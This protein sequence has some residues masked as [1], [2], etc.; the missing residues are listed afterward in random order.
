MKPG[1]VFEMKTGRAASFAFEGLGL[2]LNDSVTIVE[3]PYDCDLTA[4][5]FGEA[6]SGLFHTGPEGQRLIKAAVGTG[7]A[8]IARVSP[9]KISSGKPLNK[10]TFPSITLY[11]TG[12][13]DIC[14]RS[15]DGLSSASAGKIIV[16]GRQLGHGILSKASVTS[17][18][19]Y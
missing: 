17:S 14:W 6:I 11:R 16:S 3:T 15:A 7:D 1:K 13:F 4:V 19:R 10:V 12:E 9:Q 18:S 2:T 5:T 8:I